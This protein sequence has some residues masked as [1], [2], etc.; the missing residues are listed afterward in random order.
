MLRQQYYWFTAGDQVEGTVALVS[1]FQEQRP[2]HK[3]DFVLSKEQDP[4]YLKTW[5]AHRLTFQ[6]KIICRCAIIDQII[7]VIC[8]MHE[9]FE[10]FL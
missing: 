4:V 10:P 5:I 2:R 9:I 1:L 8:L 6:V 7:I 3:K